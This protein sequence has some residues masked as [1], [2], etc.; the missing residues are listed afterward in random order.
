MLRHYTMIV[1]G[2]I[3][4]LVVMLLGILDPIPQDIN[5]HNFADARMIFSISNFWN[6]V[7]NL[8]F[9][10]VGVYALYQIIKQKSMTYDAE[11]KQSY[12]LFFLAV[13]LVAFGSGYYHLEPNNHTLIWDRLPMVVAFMSL[14]AIVIAEFLSVHSGKRLLYPLLVFGVGSVLYWAYTESMGHGDLRLYLF[15]QFLPMIVI[16]ILLTRFKAS[17]TL[18]SGY[19]YLILCYVLAK[20][21]EYYDG[22]IYDMLG[23]I[24]GHSLKHMI[25]ALG[26]YILVRALINRERIKETL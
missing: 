9:L 23:V 17:F 13:S 11:M 14:L 26:L 1:L 5:Y 3:S 25:A 6:V 18:R 19:W 10:F 16:P 8:P 24:S 12:V 4:M 21:F 22:A 2:V 20:I 15:V 7:S